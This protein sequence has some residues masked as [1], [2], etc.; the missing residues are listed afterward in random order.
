M[1][2]LGA[3]HCVRVHAWS[4]NR[5]ILAKYWIVFYRYYWC[6]LLCAF[7]P[8][9]AMEIPGKYRIVSLSIFRIYLSLLLVPFIKILGKYTERYFIDSLVINFYIL[10]SRYRF[11]ILFV[12]DFILFYVFF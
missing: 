7:M 2:G 6:R 12:I 9:Q 8:G 5:K 1:G 11:Y 4:G 10:F 3:V